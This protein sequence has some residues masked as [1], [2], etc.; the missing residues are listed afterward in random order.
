MLFAFVGMSRFNRKVK[1][2]G[3]IDRIPDMPAVYAVGTV[4][5]TVVTGNLFFVMGHAMVVGLVGAVDSPGHS[6]VILSPSTMEAER[7]GF[8][9]DHKYIISLIPLAFSVR[10]ELHIEKGS[11]IVATV[12]M[13]L[14]HRIVKLRNGIFRFSFCISG[15]DVGGVHLDSVFDGF[16]ERCTTKVGMKQIRTTWCPTFAGRLPV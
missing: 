15:M 13:N 4:K 7:P 12:T 11:D 9:I 3:E 6:E 14:G 8:T 2:A 5:E 1:T 10:V 16:R